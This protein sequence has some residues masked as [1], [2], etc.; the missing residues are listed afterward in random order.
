[1]RLILSSILLLILAVP[2]A[3]RAQS[4]MEN[5]PQ[6]SGGMGRVTVIE[7]PEAAAPVQ[8]TAPTPVAS[9]DPYTV[10]D[11]NAD[12][13]A[14]NAAHARDQALIKAERTAFE[15]LC[16]R[17]GAPENTDK[18]SDDAIAAMVQSFEVQ[19]E[20]L[21]AVRYIGVFT[22]RFKPTALQKRLGKYMSDAAAANS[23]LTT[24]EARPV[25][26]MPL[27]HLTVAVEVNSLP[28]W[29]AVK[30]R[31]VNVSQ[32][33]RIDTLDV[34]RGLAHIDLVYGGTIA[35]L[36]NAVTDQGFVLRQNQVGDWELTDNSMV[37]R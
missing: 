28:A 16:A 11:V 24:D 31:L 32:V 14:D 19:S 21:S 13:T 18:L 33:A 10:A 17:L 7:A 27:S 22:I 3:V 35:D 25:T 37:P 15:Q 34:G 36:Q 4:I 12:V 5:L 26:A 2:A 30:R 20:H 29:A 23:P 1:M 6:G 8:S 9:G